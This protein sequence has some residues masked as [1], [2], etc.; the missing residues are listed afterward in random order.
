MRAPLSQPKYFPN[1]LPPNS[2]RLV[3][4][5][6]FNMWIWVTLRQKYLVHDKL[7]NLWYYCSYV[8]Y[9]STQMSRLHLRLFNQ[10]YLYPVIQIC[11]ELTLSSSNL[12]LWLSLSQWP[13]SIHSSNGRRCS[14]VEKTG[15]QS[16]FKF[17]TRESDTDLTRS[18]CGRGLLWEKSAHKVQMKG[19]ASSY[20]GVRASLYWWFS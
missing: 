2:I 17:H 10:H 20:C 1:I 4:R 6:L 18:N 5:A 12:I 13:T 11:Q 19:N 3:G 14:A 8:G 15:L 9:S 16:F 7:Q